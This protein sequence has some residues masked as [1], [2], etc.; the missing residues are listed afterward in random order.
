MSYEIKGT[1]LR[2]NPTVVKKEKYKSRELV[3]TVEDPKYP[4]TLAFEVSGDRC[5]SLDQ[6][7]AGDVV[8]VAFDLRGR[9]WNGP[10]G[11]RVFNTLSLWKVEVLSK[12]A[13]S[14][15]SQSGSDTDDLPF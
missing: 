13:P 1:I 2:V 14:A 11:V 10:N 8:K 12:A 5:D 4:Q 7:R 15:H 9:E 6:Y 3:L